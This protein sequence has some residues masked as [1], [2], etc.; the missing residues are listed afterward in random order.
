VATAAARTLTGLAFSHGV[1]RL[2]LRTEWENTSS[3]RVA[4]AA[5]FVREC[6]QRAGGLDRSGDRHDLIVWTRLRTDPDGP[7]HR[8][9]PDLPTHRE[10][11]DGT[12]SNSTDLGGTLTDGALTDGVVTLRPLGLGDADDLHALRSLPDV[13]ATSVPAMA[14]TPE[15]IARRSARSPAFWLAGQRADLTIRDAGTDDFAGEIGL[16]YF[17]PNTQQAM[18]GYS[19]APRWRG[20]GYATRA[21]RLVA[22]W[23]FERTDIVRLIAGTAPDNLGSQRVL[24]RAGFSFE[25]RQRS[26]LP[27][28]PGKRIDDLLYSLLPPDLG[29][30]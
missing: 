25:G 3:Q 2:S 16:Y 10:R 15:E 20:R 18:I 1:D 11:G 23:A 28:G 22:A 27:V 13:V 12:G 9:L 8:L 6:V 5:G 24:E 14:P 4:I 21:A 29:R 26:R 19:M 30:P 17:E 7:S